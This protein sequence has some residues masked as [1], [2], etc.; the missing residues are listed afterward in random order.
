LDEKAIIEKI[1]ALRQNRQITLKE[2]STRTGLTEGY[3][4]RIENAD[5]APPI[6]TL[7][8]IAEGLG[9]DVA[10]LLLPET[11]SDPE[12][13]NIVVVRR[14]DSHNGAF[15]GSPYERTVRGYQ[16]Q[17]LVEK[18]RG[19]DMEPYIL[20]PEFEAGELLQHEGEEFFYV[21]EGQIEFHYG[22]ERYIMNE[23]DCA[24]FE[25]HI[26]HSGRSLGESRAKLLIIMRQY[27]RR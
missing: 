27:K 16:Y 6:S 9:T 5:S 4:S 14:E 7:A 11:N 22:K 25:S 17:P 13:P 15:S 24:Y 10:Y 1:K 2:L 3:L 8:R 26:P 18:K 21:L 12:N 19:K 20:V 23:G